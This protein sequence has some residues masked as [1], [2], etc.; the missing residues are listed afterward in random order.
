MF[1]VTYR[2][3]NQYTGKMYEEIHLRPI[4]R[5]SKPNEVLSTAD[6]VNENY[7]KRYKGCSPFNGDKDFEVIRIQQRR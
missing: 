3:R 1:Y 5:G 2:A 4:A 7:Q 6:E